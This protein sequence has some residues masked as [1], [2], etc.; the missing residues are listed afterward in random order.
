MSYS[1]KPIWRE[2]TE[3]LMNELI[4]VA[5]LSLVPAKA[6]ERH[7]ET[8]EGAK[9]RYGVIA[10]AIASVS[11]NDRQLATFLIAV[12]KHE[13]SFTRAV[14]SGKK[15]GD[16]GRSHSLWQLMCGR[17]PISIC[18][19]S[20]LMVKDIVGVKLA[21]TTRAA[22]AAGGHLRR[23]IKSCRGRAE[24]VFKYYG[25]VSK[26]TN[27]KVQGRIDARVKTYRRLRAFLAS[28]ATR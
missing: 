21:P 2:S 15:K 25:G 27:L 10:K 3:I 19:R 6:Q 12:A 22:G 24:C 16:A 9:A 14:H 11:A 23:A 17:Y 4:L 5:M 8:A 1:L 13:S 18:P 28:R 20:G 7:G 26:T